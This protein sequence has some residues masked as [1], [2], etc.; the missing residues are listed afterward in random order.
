MDSNTTTFGSVMRL[1]DDSVLS[2]S[3]TDVWSVPVV[4]I[5]SLFKGVMFCDV[6]KVDLLLLLG[7]YAN[8]FCKGLI[9][10]KVLFINE[11]FTS[12]NWC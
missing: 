3:L 10:G 2:Y 4:N 1:F 11:F 12:L 8:K 9:I 5:E 7:H 6:N